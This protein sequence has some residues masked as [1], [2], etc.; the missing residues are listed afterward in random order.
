MLEAAQSK[1]CEMLLR[2]NA[3]LKAGADFSLFLLELL[4]IE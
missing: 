2:T 4:L 3:G 1:D